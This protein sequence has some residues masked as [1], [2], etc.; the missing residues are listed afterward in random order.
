MVRIVLFKKSGKGVIGTLIP[1]TGTDVAV[2]KNIADISKPESRKASF[3]MSIKIDG[4]DEHNM[5]LS[6][7]Y[8]VNVETLTFNRFEKQP[9]RIEVDGITIFDKCYLQLTDIE[10]SSVN[11]GREQSIMY[12]VNVKSDVADFFDKIK[13]KEITDIVLTSTDMPAHLTEEYKPKNIAVG[14]SN[15]YLAGWKT[16]LK[17]VTNGCV[18]LTDVTLAPYL[19]TL[20]NR[21]IKDAGYRYSFSEIGV[22]DS[23]LIQPTKDDLKFRKILLPYTGLPKQT[24]VEDGLFYK[25]TASNKA[26]SFNFPSATLGALNGSNQ[27]VIYPNLSVVDPSSSYT[28]NTPPTPSVYKSQFA[29]VLKVRSIMTSGNLRINNPNASD[30][31]F[32]PLPPNVGA[33]LNIYHQVTA[34]KN[35][36]FLMGVKTL[37]HTISAGTQFSSGN[38]VLKT[39]TSVDQ[40]ITIPVLPNDE[41]YIKESFHVDSFLL[42]GVNWFSMPTGLP[43]FNFYLNIFSKKNTLEFYATEMTSQSYGSIMN[44]NNFLPEKVKQ[45]DFIKGVLNLFNILVEIDDEDDRLLVFKTRNYYYDNGN[46]VDLTRYLVKEK[47]VSQTFLSDGQKKNKILTY[48][49]GNGVFDKKYKEATGVTYGQCTFTFASEH[50]FG[51][52]KLEVMFTPAIMWQDEGYYLTEYPTGSVVL[53]LENDA[54]SKP[55]KFLGWSGGG[56]YTVSSYYPT[57]HLDNALNPSFDLNFNYCESYFTANQ[58]VTNNNL[59]N[60]FHRRTFIQIDNGRACVMYFAL[61]PHIFKSLKLDSRVYVDG[62]RYI[63]NS[64]EN[65][66]PSKTTLTKT[67]LITADNNATF[68]TRLR[69]LPAGGTGVSTPLPTGGV[70]PPLPLMSGNNIVFDPSTGVIDSTKHI[71]GVSNIIGGYDAIV[72]GNGNTVTGNGTK[73][74][75]D[76]ITTDMDGDTVIN[77][78]SIMQNTFVTPPPTT[79]RPFIMKVNTGA[80]GNFT[81]PTNAGTY[82]YSVKVS[83]GQTFDFQTGS[84]TITLPASTDF[85]IEILGTFGQFYFYADSINA[86]KVKEI[87]QWGDIVWGSYQYFS[88]RGCQ[89]LIVSA[90]D[91]PKTSNVTGAYG[92]FYSCNSLKLD[93]SNWDFSQCTTMTGFMQDSS[94]SIKGVKMLN[95]LNVTSLQQFFW[96]NYG[97]NAA[98]GSDVQE[99]NTS[100]SL[101]T[102]WGFNSGIFGT[103][104]GKTKVVISECG[105]VT[106][107]AYAFHDSTGSPTLQWLELWNIKISFEVHSQTSMSLNGLTALANSVS[108]MT[109]YT[110]PTVKLP[111]TTAGTDSGMVAI[112]TGKNWIVT[113]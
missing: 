38:T 68:N 42:S 73:V 67:T 34:Y 69:G 57:I 15:S 45:S 14:M 52:D 64:I 2:T 88:F 59:F 12:T 103:G 89:N 106:D 24:N 101:T 94:A 86:L 1:V 92:T 100:S 4:A 105:G 30:I 48:K 11:E 50:N 53:V 35:G 107:S 18:G 58:L 104:S 28:L 7:I 36:V 47:G 31:K 80:S 29:G 74:I 78:V 54:I 51:D 41:V 96:G 49:S 43:A 9:C 13:V 72:I 55:V 5:V 77:G 19:W 8:G 44:F 95:L 75:G 112:F 110:S 108:D 84:L 99:F 83:D 66:N 33:N 16:C 61:K 17:N 62:A 91:T 102:L 87:T 111:S 25:V 109:G 26:S 10:Y 65:Y 97:C 56:D 46:E 98:N 81:I 22:Q 113:Y 40:W 63:V 37:I 82:L 76:G 90:T 60:L 27:S 79:D 6:S 70:K 23:V 85:T 39:T 32:L 20:W 3:S 21:I 71:K 93:V